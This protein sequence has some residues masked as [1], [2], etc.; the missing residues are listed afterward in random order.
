M[1]IVAVLVD[2]IAEAEQI[3]FFVRTT[4]R[5]VNRKQDRHRYTAA[6]EANS[7]RDF[8]VAKQEEAIK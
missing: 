2:D 7:G 6:D 3:Q 5:N 4:T 8:Q 1:R